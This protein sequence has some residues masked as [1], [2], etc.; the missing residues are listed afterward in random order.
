MFVI[1]NAVPVFILHRVVENPPAL[2]GVMS[3]HICHGYQQQ[4]RKMFKSF[5]FKIFVGNCIFAMEF[6]FLQ[7]Q[8]P[9]PTKN[10]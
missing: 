7:T 2:R 6:N 1:L 8:R 4:A 5:K 9:H 10:I 3:G